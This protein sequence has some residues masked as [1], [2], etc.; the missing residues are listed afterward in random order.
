MKKLNTRLDEAMSVTLRPS[1]SQPGSF[2]V[3]SVGSKMKAH[4]GIKPGERVKDSHIDDF[5]DSG[6]KV[7]YHKEGFMDTVKKGVDKVKKVKKDIQNFHKTDAAA[8]IRKD[9]AFIKKKASIFDESSDS[10]Q[11]MADT[12]NDHADHKDP[13]VQTHIKKAEKAYNDKDHEGFIH[14]TQKAAD[15]AYTLKY[16]GKPKGVTQF[17][18][19]RKPKPK[20]EA[21]ERRADRKTIIATD[22]NTGRKVLKVPPKKE[23]E[24]GKGKME[25][26]EPSMNELSDKTKLSY[27]D[28]RNKQITDKEKL[29]LNIGAKVDKD[30]NLSKMRKGV[31]MAKSKLGEDNLQEL[32]PELINKV[33]HKRAVNTSMELSK[34]HGDTRS[35]DY[36][37][38]AD[39]QKKNAS[40]RFSAGAKAANRV[41]KALEKRF[42]DQKEGYKQDFKRKEIGHELGN[43]VNRKTSKPKLSMA[44]ITSGGDKKVVT[45]P[46]RKEETVAEL[47]INTM[48]TY[49]SAAAADMNDQ[50]NA[51]HKNYPEKQIDA[52]QAKREKGIR[53]ADKR[54]AKKQVK[55]AKGVAFDKRYKGRNM[56]GASKAIDKIKPG[57]SDH[58]KVKDA[59]RRA[60]EEFKLGE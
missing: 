24:I 39:K 28:K 60:N 27:I 12:W 22:P 18:R 55:M 15:H 38:A 2:K 8:A 26:V 46:L 7:K 59:L 16:S 3:H 1:K 48:K 9:G 41:G 29:H 56:T 57:L 50:E 10:V 52:R 20:N 54:I 30:K 31:A 25:S 53:T 43:E 45:N 47:K 33:A 4:G 58:P 32:S 49:Q 36:K 44:G 34:A 37:S 42:K 17:D 5:H 11:R 19:N 13:K 14:H 40:L 21:I 6:I 35:P 51:R 23:I